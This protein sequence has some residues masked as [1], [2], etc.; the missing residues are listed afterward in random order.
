MTK[1]EVKLVDGDAIVR[2]G[3]VCQ[4]EQP[5]TPRAL[6]DFREIGCPIQWIRQHP[7]KPPA[8]TGCVFSERERERQKRDRDQKATENG[9]PAPFLWGNVRGSDTLHES[10]P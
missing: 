9:Y 6:T 4:G 1:R 8:I 3:R 5:I 7:H 10:L 2:F